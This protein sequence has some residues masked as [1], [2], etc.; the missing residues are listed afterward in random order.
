M[1]YVK[2]MLISS[3]FLPLTISQS[4]NFPILAYD[5]LYCICN[6]LVNKT[7][8]IGLPLCLLINRIHPCSFMWLYYPYWGSGSE[9]VHQWV[10]TLK[11]LGN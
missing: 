6:G 9:Y 3:P 7:V 4:Y 1:P 2:V 10:P 5:L 11:M 8:R